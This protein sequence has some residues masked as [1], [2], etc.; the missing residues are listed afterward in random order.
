MSSMNDSSDIRHTTSNS[1]SRKGHSFT[2]SLRGIIWIVIVLVLCAAS[3]MG[4]R[5]Y[6]KSH[7]ASTTTVSTTGSGSQFGGGFGG[8]GG[9]RQG[10]FGQV[11]AVSAT[12]ITINN[13]RSNASST[14]SISSSTTITDAGQTVAYSDIQVGDTVAI[15]VA[16]SG[17]TAATRIMIN[18]GFGGGG[19]GGGG[20]AS[21]GTGTAN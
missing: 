7:T 4:G 1:P 8:G 5:S 15:S 11:T 6:Q 3:F 21:P 14:Y 20:G 19:G 18:P 9:R 16:S 17:S 13:T 10:A 2:F 12:S